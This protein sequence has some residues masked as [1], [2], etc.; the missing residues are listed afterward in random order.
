MLQSRRE[1]IVH[2]LL[3]AARIAQKI[4]VL[5][6]W[7]VWFVVPII[8][9][10]L[11]IYFV[12]VWPILAAAAGLIVTFISVSMILHHLSGEDSQAW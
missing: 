7:A 1:E 4:A 8:S 9:W 10:I 5:V 12:G 2:L 3:P 11:L 6:P